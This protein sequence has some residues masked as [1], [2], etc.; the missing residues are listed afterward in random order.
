MTKL[1]IQIPCYNE[2]ETLPQTLADLPIQID[3]IDAIE[4]LVIDD[5]SKDGTVDVARSLGVAHVVRQT[6]NRGLA[7]TFVKGL[8]TALELGA[9]IIVN[10]DGDNQYRGSDIER[11]VRPIGEGWADIVVGDRGVM[12]VA[13]FSPAK[14]RLQRLGSWVM[15][16]ASGVDT[17]DAT[18]GFRALSREAA[19]RTII[20]SQ[21]S[22]TLESLIQAGARRM[23][24][25]YVPIQVNPSTRKSRLMRNIPDYIANSAATILRTYTMYR[26]LR[27]F[28]FIGGV[29]IAAGLVLGGRFV[30]Y[31]LQGQGGG[32]VQS[33]ILT[34]ILLIAGFQSCLIGLLADLIGFNRKV[35]E[36]ILYRLRR[37][38]LPG[39]HDR[40]GV[41]G[42]LDSDG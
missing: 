22:Y 24:V 34:A 41:A 16:L 1:I 5:G 12:Q 33:L 37:L 27:V 40:D 14:R 2:A 6:R 38:E 35:L 18:S 8:E 10:T 30:W 31:Y 3:G 36:E 29:M 4:V 42:P 9:D 19:L 39:Q 32:K 20:L 7:S 13:E 28:L 21:Y 17:P 11:L 25:Q 23:S 26:P 15:K